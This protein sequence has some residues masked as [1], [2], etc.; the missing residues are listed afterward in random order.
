MKKYVRDVVQYL[1]DSFKGV[2][3]VL[4]YGEDRGLVSELFEKASKS[5]VDDL[6]DSFTVFD[7]TP[8][9]I[10][11]DKSLLF[12]NVQGMTLLG[13]R[14]LIRIKW[15]GNRLT[16][17]LKD[18]ITAF[19]AND[20][21]IVVSAAELETSS[22][23]R[24]FFENAKKKDLLSIGCYLDDGTTA[25]GMKQFFQAEGVKVSK[26]VL[27]YLKENL[28]QDKLS[29][30]SELQKLVLY[31][32]DKKEVTLDDARKCVG[33]SSALGIENI[34]MAMTKFDAMEAS[35]AFQRLLEEGENTVMILRSLQF[36]FKKIYSICAAIEGGTDVD[37]ALKKNGI[38]FWKVVPFY[39]KYIGGWNT[40]K[41]LKAL[42]KFQAL[43]MKFKEG[44][45]PAQPVDLLFSHFILEFCTVFKR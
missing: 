24:K 29:T 18:A 12:D 11:R 5:V 28:G 4:F 14:K 35:V 17:A 23:L 26:D 42:D 21:F 25:V 40:R 7:L 9:E 31:V 8:E 22:S 19:N 43:D 16:D 39:K 13:G 36:H 34:T 1:D 45:S 33:D 38:M 3:A 32:G 41:A 2:K 44:G 15:A 10:Q 20:A 27:D 30:M 6:T 37:S